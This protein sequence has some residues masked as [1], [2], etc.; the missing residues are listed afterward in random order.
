MSVPFVVFAMPRSRSA[1]LSRYLSYG[2]W[3]VGH[4]EL[5]YCRSLADVDSWLAQPCI[6]TVETTAAPFWRLLKPGTRVVTVHRPIE[7]VMAS[8]WRGGLAFDGGVMRAVLEHAEAKLR[9]IAARLP[10][11]V[12]VTFDEL[13]YETTCQ[14]V[15]EHCLGL[16]HDR[17]WW[18][19]WQGINIQ[20]SL[21]Q[22]MRYYTAHA[23]QIEKLRRL[24]KH[25]VLRRFRRPVEL[26]G[27]VFQ[28]EPLAQAFSDP[29]GMRLM[30]EECVLLGEEPEAWRHMNIPLLE[31]IEAKGNLH[32]YTARSNGRMFG[33]LVSAIGEAFHAR[34]QSEADQVSFYAD[35]TWPGLGRKLQH[36]AIEDLRAKG[37]D[38]VLMFQPDE[39][40]VG[41]VYRRLGARQTGQRFV[42]E[43]N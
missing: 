12:S 21:G 41:L 40:R 3:H 18:Q 9:Q 19:H 7:Q 42:L 20:V 22:T 30:A 32:I 37:V 28:Q 25:E 31:R 11:V 1:W 8:L 6:G 29:D 23:A 36:A 38:R 39:T 15:F 4:D 35:P 34:D 33:Y 26:N 14:R 24:A 17:A 16:P 10:D 5:R 2:A 27:V 43:L 13:A